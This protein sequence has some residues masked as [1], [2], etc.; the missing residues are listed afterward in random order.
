VLSRQPYF[1]AVQRGLALTLP[2]IMVGAVALLVKYPPIGALAVFRDEVFGEQLDKLADILIAST[3]GIGALVALAGLAFVFTSARNG[4]SPD[5]SVSPIVSVL[6]ALSAFLVVSAPDTEQGFHDAISFGQGLPVALLVGLTATPLFLWLSRI[7]SLRMSARSIG[8][9]RVIGDVFSLL[10]AAM[11]TVF[12]FALVKL[13][14]GHL[15]SHD[16]VSD[17]NDGLA[18]LMMT[19]DDSVWFG[20]RYIL[21]SQILWLFGIHGP[22]ILR[23]VHDQQLVPASVEN[24]V[25]VLEGVEP[26]RIYTSQFFDL[27]HM[28][29][30]GVTIALII[31][32]LIGSRS[33]GMRRL[34]LI[35]AIPAVC[36]INEP[37]L[38]GLPIVFNPVM[39]I[40]FVLAPLLSTLIMY[41]AIAADFMPAT[42]YQVAWTTPPVFN[43]F[44]VTGSINGAIVQAVCI[45]LSV[46]LY[47]PFV[48]LSDEVS[49][50]SAGRSMKTLLEIAEEQDRRTVPVV[51]LSRAGEE[52]RI[53]SALARDLEEALKSPGQ[54]KLAY[55]P[56]FD[57][58]GQIITGLEALLRWEHPI[59]G[60]V[61]PPVTVQLAEELDL[62]AEL[63]QAVLLQAVQQRKAL[64]ELLPSEA[65]MGVNVSPTEV[66]KP[67]FADRVLKII[68]EAGGDPR[69]IELEI[70][71]TT[72]LIPDASAMDTLSY[73]REAGVK[74]A[75]DDFG[76]GHTSLRYLRQL[77]LDTVKVDRSLVISGSNDVSTHIVTSI[78]DLSITMGFSVV[79]EG[80]ERQDQLI[81]FSAIGCERFQGY[82]FCRPM[83]A[84]D[85]QAFLETQ[86][87]K[88]EMAA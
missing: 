74:I 88:A 26:V 41:L 5:K 38:Y 12:V 31:A 27:V 78:L 34:G 87:T 85:C 44:A 77:P 22:N 53:A 33:P 73:L 65:V 63:G 84:K 25:A 39:A 56:Q 82:L 36:N 51:L 81:R 10:P 21:V 35:A 18:R 76:M 4:A 75:L 7:G 28:G 64:R 30:S 54:L 83:F 17:F 57:R 23:G 2:L 49:R 55:Q 32:I 11:I 43:G 67:G 8:N 60:P 71:E 58:T 46:G 20:L 29:G 66:A 1:L 69:E 61:P 37:L 79:I 45:A 47:L 14:L 48:R 70:T 15:G 9:D 72:A 40:P 62:I 19:G 86:N 6:V 52:G 16:V 3:F 42:G 80:I 59:Y 50:R 24:N 13:L 68:R